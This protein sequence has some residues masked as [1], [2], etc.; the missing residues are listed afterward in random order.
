MRLY[1]IDN[2]LRSAMDD[3]DAYAEE[4][5][6]V[7]PDDLAELIDGLTM[8]RDEKIH[9]VCLYVLEL[10]ASAQANKDAENRIRD[11]RKYVE[12][13]AERLREY[14]SR[15]VVPG[16]KHEWPDCKQSWRRSEAV[17][18]MSIDRI[19]K[20]YVEV[21]IEQVPDKASIKASIKAGNV[22]PGAELTVRQNLQIK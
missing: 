1:E 17:E 19:P 3:A 16:E 11:R 13:K 20:S 8:A 9:H 14:L 5:E 12:G 7:I 4:H 18:I 2:L 10:E 6:G 21:R 15:L 22:V